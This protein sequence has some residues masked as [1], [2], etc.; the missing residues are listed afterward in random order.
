[1]VRELRT[2]MALVFIAGLLALTAPQTAAS[3]G[4][5]RRLA[6]RSAL[7]AAVLALPLS[8]A[9]SPGCQGTQSDMQQSFP[10]FLAEATT[11]C[12]CY[13]GGKSW[14]PGSIACMGGWK[15]R[16][17]DAGALG[18]G[19]NPVRSGK[20]QVRCDGGEHCK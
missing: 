16:C 18:C 19:W 1:M 12:V 7:P 6:A 9:L 17:V 13:C 20:D 5:N 8:E 15:H 2:T 3:T 10:T 11:S 14:S 4:T